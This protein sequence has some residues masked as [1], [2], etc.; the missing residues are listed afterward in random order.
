[1]WDFNKNYMIMMS[2]FPHGKV[3]LHGIPPWLLCRRMISF[4]NL[5][6]T[7]HQPVKNGLSIQDSSGW[8]LMNS[9]LTHWMRIYV[10]Y[11]FV[12]TFE[13]L[14]HAKLFWELKEFDVENWPKEHGIQS[15]KHASVT[16][17]CWGIVM[18][19]GPPSVHFLSHSGFVLPFMAGP[20]TCFF[21]VPL[22]LCSIPV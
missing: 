2:K 22:M 16:H 5:D 13:D 8:F 11:L 4:P 3:F 1:M 15:L 18:N 7:A 6:E 21:F 19:A 10:S 9:N 20:K 14:H 17:V 12:L